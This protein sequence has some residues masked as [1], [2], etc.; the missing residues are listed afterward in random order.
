MELYNYSSVVPLNNDVLD[1][2]SNEISIVSNAALR[3]NRM[4]M[5]TNLLSE[6]KRRSLV[7]V[8]GAVS[9]V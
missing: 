3:S 6:A 7:T 9:V 1:I 8:T 4:S 5:E 2:L